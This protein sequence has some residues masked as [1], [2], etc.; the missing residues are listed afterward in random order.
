MPL[1]RLLLEK[2]KNQIDKKSAQTELVVQR[3]EPT[4]SS[5]DVEVGSAF[6]TSGGRAGMFL[7]ICCSKP[8]IRVR[9]LGIWPFSA[10]LGHI[11]VKIGQNQ[12][13][14]G[15]QGAFSNIL[16]TQHAPK[17]IFSQNLLNSVFSIEN[18]LKA[19]RLIKGQNQLLRAVLYNMR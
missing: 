1:N 8:R 13:S 15:S 14:K 3:N 11:L 19:R 9:R 6:K 12:L 5:L 18:D 2:T 17:K 10:V 4:T 7:A 16:V